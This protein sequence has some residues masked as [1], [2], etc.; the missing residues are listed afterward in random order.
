MGILT[1]AATPRA[2]VYF[3]RAIKWRNTLTPTTALKKRR[4]TT[5]L[6]GVANLTMKHTV[7]QGPFTNSANGMKSTKS[8]VSKK[9]LKKA[10]SLKLTL[11]GFMNF[12]VW[13]PR[14]GIFGYINGSCHVLE[15]SFTETER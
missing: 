9:T 6:M 2:A 1:F 3:K 11:P 12:K 14:E 13:L 5:S 8:A 7:K 4:S 15:T 10:K